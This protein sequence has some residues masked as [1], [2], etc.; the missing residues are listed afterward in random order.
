MAFTEEI[1]GYFADF[2]VDAVVGGVTVR[3]IF[4]NSFLDTL[5][6]VAGTQ[7]MVLAKSADVSAISVGA[8]VTIA[9]VIYAVAEIQPDGT[10]LTRLMLK[11]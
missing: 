5:G 4:D 9:S 3:C 2:G 8:A 11:P 1:A 10:G 6:I 7:P